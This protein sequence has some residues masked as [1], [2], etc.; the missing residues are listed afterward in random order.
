MSY[1]P[2]TPPK[3]EITYEDD[4]TIHSIYGS[5]LLTVKGTAFVYKWCGLFNV[6]CWCLV[7]H[8]YSPDKLCKLRCDDSFKH[9]DNPD[10]SVWDTLRELR[11]LQ[12]EWDARAE[13]DRPDSFWTRHT[14]YLLGSRT[15]TY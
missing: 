9:R 11:R 5:G 13:R 6:G 8:P 10:L 12:R 1:N 14:A 7:P 2:Y 4:L 15:S 3:V